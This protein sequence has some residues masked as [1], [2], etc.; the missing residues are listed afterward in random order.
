MA[1]PALVPA[2]SFGYYLAFVPP[3]AA[4][5]IAQPA[6]PW[7]GRPELDGR[8][9]FANAFGTRMRWQIWAGFVLVA[10]VASMAPLALPVGDGGFAVVLSY[11]GMLWSIVVIWA[12][13]NAALPA[14]TGVTESAPA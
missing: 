10:I 9:L 14:R 11:T 4:V 3:L 2:L 8:G 13:V 1:L 6:V 5:I 7:L 12:A